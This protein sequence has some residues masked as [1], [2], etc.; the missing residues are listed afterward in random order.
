MRLLF[1]DT[2]GAMAGVAVADG[3]KILAESNLILDRRMSARLLAVIQS[4]LT[5][6]GMTVADLEGIGV[7]CGPGSFTGVRIGMATVKGMALAA[8]V[9]VAGVSSLAL[10]AANLPHARYNVCALMDA[11][12]QEVY[13]GSFRC[14]SI[15]VAISPETVLPPGLLLDGIMERTIFVGDGATVYRELIA[16]RCGDLA[17][18]VP[19][20]S[21]YPRGACGVTLTRAA[22]LAGKGMT[23]E[24]LES[25]YIRA[26]EAETAKAA[27]GKG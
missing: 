19:P 7:A 24:Q 12:K 15:P 8:G 27:K 18:F 26:S 16:D 10:L 14:E 23:P 22:F 25:V 5:E 20:F 1:V 13:A 17:T 11:R 2:C 3:G 4:L 21:N 6:T 9:P